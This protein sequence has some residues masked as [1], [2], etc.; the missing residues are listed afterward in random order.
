MLGPPLARATARVI[1]LLQL[2]QTVL[3]VRSRYEPDA[4]DTR[5]WD[6]DPEGEFSSRHACTTGVQDVEEGG[7]VVGGFVRFYTFYTVSIL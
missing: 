6:R 5:K 2:D 3:R 1:L 7:R 4:R